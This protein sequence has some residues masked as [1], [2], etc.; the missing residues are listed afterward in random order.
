MEDAGFPPWNVQDE[1]VIVPELRLVKSI[2]V[3]EQITSLL[4]VNDT[5]GEGSIVMLTGCETL[6]EPIALLTVSVTV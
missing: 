6:D 4:A 3:P 1:V 5:E 2:H